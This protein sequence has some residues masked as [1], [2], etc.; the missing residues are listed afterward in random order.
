MK[1]ICSI[2]IMATIMFC[3]NARLGQQRYGNNRRMLFKK[4]IS[5]KR[6]RLD[7]RMFLHNIGRHLED[8]KEAKKPYADFLSAVTNTISV[9]DDIANTAKNLQ[10]GVM[11]CL[12]RKQLLS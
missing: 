6:R 2:L 1:T 12:I 3:T 11:I 9:V 10:T 4:W 5:N 7:N 8:E